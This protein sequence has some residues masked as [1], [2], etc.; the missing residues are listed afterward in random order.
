MSRLAA[1]VVIGA[2]IQR[3]DIKFGRDI[4]RVRRI[5]ELLYGSH[6][7]GHI[8]ER[9]GVGTVTFQNS[10]LRDNCPLKND[11]CSDQM[12]QT[13]QAIRK[14]WEFLEDANLSHTDLSHVALYEADLKGA[15]LDHVLITDADFHCADLEDTHWG[16]TAAELQDLY[17]HPP[18]MKY[19]NVRGVQP[20]SF[21]IWATDKGKAVDYSH[22]DWV[23]FRSTLAECQDWK[24][25][26]LK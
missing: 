4:E 7:H 2:A 24:Q 12:E 3:D 9:W 18:N 23:K 8:N 20:E 1:A 11:D 26:E 21:R 15:S 22:E 5:K 6:F 19:A 10:F 17:D 25:L 13:R 16:Q 14:N